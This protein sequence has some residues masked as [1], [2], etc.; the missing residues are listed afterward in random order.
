M[1]LLSLIRL[2]GGHM[3]RFTKNDHGFMALTL[4]QIGLIIAAGILIAAIFS[5]VFQNDWQKNAELTNIA[6]SFST[7]VEGTDARFFE[8]TT[9]FYFPDIGYDYNVSISTEYLVVKAQGNWNNELSAK[10]RFLVRPWPQDHTSLWIGGTELHDHLKNI[11]GNSG[12]VSDPVSNTAKNYLENKWNTTV[13]SLASNPIYILTN[14][15]IYVDKAI[16][17]YDN[18]KMEDLIFVY[19]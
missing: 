4:S 10:E 1:S 7:I 13:E 8:N 18:G 15:T 9:S 16:I 11:F 5:I 12:N 2:M 3:S 17:Y 19:Q 6:T 14:R